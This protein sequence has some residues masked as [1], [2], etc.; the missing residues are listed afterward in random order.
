KGIFR[1]DKKEL[2]GV[3][4]RQTANLNPALYGT[5]DGMLTRE[6]SGGG[7][8]AAWKMNDG[9][10][11]FAT[12]KGGATGDSD[13]LAVNSIPPPLVIEQLRID[14]QAAPLT[15]S[16]KVAAGSTRFDF[17]YTAPSFIAPENVRFKY[18]LEGFDPDWIDGGNRRVAY[19]TNLLP[20]S[21]RFGVMAANNDGVWN[22]QG[23]V[24]DFYL[25]PRFYQT[26]WFYALV[27]LV[28][29]GIVGQLYRLRV[30]RISAQFSAVLGE[31]N[32]IAREI[33]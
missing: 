10:L 1:L 33:H 16:L 20:G 4:A 22:E 7:H 2:D 15:A 29:G 9:K 18:K 19:Y 26:Y 32:R 12:I 5:A 14:D 23:A 6:C 27:L 17:Y 24:L 25:R 30:Q 28:L 13:H 8:P 11:W 3:A 21:Y 31:R